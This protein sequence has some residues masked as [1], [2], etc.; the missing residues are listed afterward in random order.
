MYELEKPA[1][2]LAISSS[3]KGIIN[4]YTLVEYGTACFFLIKTESP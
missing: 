3:K 4:N 2:Q 1:F